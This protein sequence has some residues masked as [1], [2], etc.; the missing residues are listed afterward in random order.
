MT[1]GEG[2]AVRRSTGNS[3]VDDVGFLSRTQTN[4]TLVSCRPSR[5][6]SLIP[7][8]R[9]NNKKAQSSSSTSSRRPGRPPKVHT[10]SPRSQKSLAAHLSLSSKVI[11]PVPSDGNCLFSSISTSLVSQSLSS[12]DPTDVRRRITGELREHR[13]VYEPF[14]T[15]A[16]R[17]GEFGDED[18]ED[19]QDEDYDGYVERMEGD[20]EWGGQMEM[21]A[22]ARVYGRVV[23]VYMFSDSE[24]SVTEAVFEPE[25]KSKGRGGRTVEVAFDGISHYVGV[26]NMSGR[27]REGGTD[28]EGEG[29]EQEEGGREETGGGG[30][31]G[32]GS[33][34]SA[35]LPAV[36][37]AAPPP[38]K[39]KTD[40]CHCGSGRAFKRCCMKADQARARARAR[41]EKRKKEDE[42]R[43]R[44]EEE[45]GGEGGGKGEAGTVE[46]VGG[47]LGNL[48]LA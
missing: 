25:G 14:F 28:D 40:A 19:L 30:G 34:L 37:S 7:M 15:G 43:R 35:T 23:R 13:D 22:A 46:D 38:P 29:S 18:L 10:S 24:S 32:G 39:R 16:G 27:C 42:E 33:A 47:I 3:L 45:E 41:V 8:P 11:S 17:N 36:P 31:G 12:D 4:N 6:H 48:R 26:L 5:G 9:K 1:I 21:L 44:K 20:G 2:C